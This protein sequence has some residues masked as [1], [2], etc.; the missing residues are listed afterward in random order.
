MGPR[1]MS[2][3]KVSGKTRVK[4][5]NGAS[6]GPRL[7]SRGKLSL[8]LL[9]GGPGVRASMGP[10]LMSRGKGVGGKRPF[11]CMMELQWGRGS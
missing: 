4:Y 5:Q 6:M 11:A 8:P 10:R 9:A 1:L 7:M 2:R 3:G